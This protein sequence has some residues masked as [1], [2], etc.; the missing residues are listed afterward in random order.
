MVSMRIWSSEGPA[1]AFQGD[2]LEE[3]GGKSR[4]TDVG[5]RC[6]RFYGLFYRYPGSTPTAASQLYLSAMDLLAIQELLRHA[7]VATMMQYVHVQR[8]WIEE[9]G[10][11]GSERAAK[12]LEG[13]LP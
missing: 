8:T 7:W 12:R 1:D 5:W 4:P 13:L 9:A 11:A 3:F 2:A 10:I 6:S